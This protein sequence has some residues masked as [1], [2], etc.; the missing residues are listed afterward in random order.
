MDIGGSPLA[1]GFWA[2]QEASARIAVIALN[3]NNLR[4]EGSIDA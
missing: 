1:G 2:P 3:P 4:W